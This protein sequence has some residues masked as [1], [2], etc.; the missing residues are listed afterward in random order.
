MQKY[1]HI[2]ELFAFTRKMLALMFLYSINSLISSGT[3]STPKLSKETIS[4][5][6]QNK[7]NQHLHI[8][9]GLLHKPQPLF[10]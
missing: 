9:Q 6:L 3:Y 5:F 8:H 4:I 10:F 2:I 7:A 1:P